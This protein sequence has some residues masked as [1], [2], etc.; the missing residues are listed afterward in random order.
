MNFELDITQNIIQ[1][2]S[3]Q[4]ET[5]IVNNKLDFPPRLGSGNME[6][7]DFPNDL[8]FYHFIFNMN[9]PVAMHS[10]NP[11]DSDWLLL[12]INLSKVAVEKTVNNQ[13]VNIQRYLPSGILF[14][15]ANTNVYSK[16]PPNQDYEIVLIRIHKKLLSSYQDSGFNALYN[17]ENAV[18]YEDLDYQMERTLRNLIN[19]KQNKIRAHAHLMQFLADVVDKLNR[20]E[21]EHNFDHLHPN[22]IK[23]LFMA[24]AHLRNP[25]TDDIPSIIALSEIAAMGTTKF[26]TTFKQ[27]FGL[28]PMQY[29]KKIK[30]DYAKQELENKRKTPSQLSYELGYSHPSKFTQAFKKQFG[31]IPS[32]LN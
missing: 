9:E 30:F 17:S 7:L 12:N 28:P 18:I 26:K 27:V 24:A 23:G 2:F 31:E 19:G 16:T 14:Y 32:A 10:F 21:K 8:E 4:L 3:K 25:L 13:E 29:H 22:D 11:P 6:L 1:Q 5:D 20:R 15:S